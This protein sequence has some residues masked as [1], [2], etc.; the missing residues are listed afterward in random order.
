M[1]VPQKDPHRAT[2][3]AHTRAA[4][5]RALVDNERA[6]HRRREGREL[7][8]PDAREVFCESR[9]VV[10]IAVDRRGAK[11]T[12]VA[13]IREES[14][15]AVGE[16]PRAP[17]P[18]APEEVRHHEAQELLDGQAH[19]IRQL[20]VPTRA[21]A[22][23]PALGHPLRDE[24]VEVHRQLVDRRRAVRPGELAEVAEHRDAV[25]DIPRRV[26]VLGEPRHVTLDR[27]PIH[28]ARTR[29]TVS[30]RRK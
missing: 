10:A 30:G 19:L 9:Q 24:R 3:V 11:P 29:S 23:T 17:G 18:P 15:R 28:D 12:L 22:T 8:P 13:Q 4:Q 7:V 21:A 5:A 25:M 1:E 27:L 20:L 26:P 2:E 6:Q 16:R 14:R